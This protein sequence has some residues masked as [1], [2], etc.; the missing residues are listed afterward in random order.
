M[1]GQ[2]ERGAM[3]PVQ[4][5]YAR[6]GTGSAIA[7]R[8]LAALHEVAGADVPV[9]PQALAPFDHIHGRGLLATRDLVALLAPAEGE[10]ILDIG[11][12]IGGPARWIASEVRCR[13]TGVDLTAEF[14]A[15]AE[16][17]TLACGLSHTVPIHQGSA[18]ALPLPD[19]AFDKA[20][21]HNV[22][23]N[24]ADKAGVYREA[25]R[26]LKPGGRLVLC[27]L[28]AGDGPVRAYPVPWASGP[29]T[30][31]L[32]TDEET[33]RD[34]AA[35]GFEILHF[36]DT[37]ARARAAA[38]AMRRELEAS[39]LPSAG[40]HVFGGS[41]SYLEELINNAAATEAGLIRSVEIVARKPA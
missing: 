1:I 21:S 38:P 5:H 41:R 19:A 20:Y 39:G 32:A 10:E 12:G 16:A 2:E 26:V 33:R 4:E 29:D 17:L 31:F 8:I 3:H 6:A 13:V 14:C 36:G 11:C 37:S 27:H 40:P 22:V 23:M 34:L 35:A 9:T 28:N 30:S 25:F 15:A 24:I 7:E 18:L